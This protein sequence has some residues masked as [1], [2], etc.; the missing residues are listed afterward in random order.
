[1]KK[2]YASP[3]LE[4]INEQYHMGSKL[5]KRVISKKN[6]TYRTLV[7]IIDRHIKKG[8]SVIDFGSGVGTLDFYLA[9][10]GCDIYGIDFSQIAVDMSKRNAKNLNL[11]NKTKFVKGDL[12]KVKAPGI[13]DA[14]LMTEVIEHLPNEKLILDTAYK[15]LKKGGLII[16]STRSKN[17]PLKKIGLVKNHDKHVGHLHRYTTMRLEKLAKASKFTIIEKGM[18]EGLLKDF[19]F[20]YPKIGSQIVRVAN[21]FGL[22]SDLLEIIDRIFIKVFGMSQVYIVAK[23]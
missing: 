4:N 12:A 3:D 1:M 11:A 6:F 22:F 20:S 15:K 13:Y 23:K 2:K 9:S 7:S 5:Q 18:N 19:L 16:V 17:A 14:L 8:M 21:K 10:R